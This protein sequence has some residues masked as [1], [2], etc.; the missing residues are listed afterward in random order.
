MGDSLFNLLRLGEVAESS[1]NE[2]KLNSPRTF[3][4]Y[5]KLPPQELKG[6]HIPEHKLTS[7]P[8]SIPP[9]QPEKHEKKSQQKRNSSLL[10]FGN[11]A[12]EEGG[13]G[14]IAVQIKS[15]HDI[16]TKDKRLKKEVAKSNENTK[17]RPSIFIS[18]TSTNENEEKTKSSTEELEEYKKN[19]AEQ[20]KTQI[21]ALK[22]GLCRNETKSSTTS[23]VAV[24]LT[25]LQEL[26]RKYTMKTLSK[27]TKTKM[28]SSTVI[29]K[30][31]KKRKEEDE[32]NT[33]QALRL[34]KNRLTSSH[35]P[36]SSSSLD[37][38]QNQIIKKKETFTCKLHF[39]KNC[40]SCTEN[41]AVE[42][43]S[44]SDEG[45]LSHWLIFDKDGK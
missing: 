30:V 24:P 6:I 25:K 12:E 26:K 9:I 2:D 8:A 36:S 11:E 7:P 10:S 35:S 14:F 45:W 21:E 18:T 19:K 28:P 42:K 4:A 29:E 41:F 31:D 43:Q 13:D 39:I 27:P 1:Q 34:F 37:Q 15:S 38:E 20:V 3:T 32:L 16:L 40:K 5:L 23:S 17:E 22:Q 33:L 44:E